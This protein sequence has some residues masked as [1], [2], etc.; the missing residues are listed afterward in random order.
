MQ[1]SSICKRQKGQIDL[2]RDGY[3]MN[4]GS[5]PSSIAWHQPQTVMA[6]R[7]PASSSTGTPFPSSNKP[8]A[9]PRTPNKQTRPSQRTLT[10]HRRPPQPSA[11]APTWTPASPA[12]HRAWMVGHPHP[13][14]CHCAVIQDVISHCLRVKQHKQVKSYALTLRCVWLSELL[15]LRAVSC[16]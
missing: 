1:I 5:T 11:N 6:P 4:I 15:R 8:S 2:H 9:L 14:L 12:S 7:P 13:L 10:S 3:E 16:D